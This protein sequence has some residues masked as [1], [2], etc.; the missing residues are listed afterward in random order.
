MTD[1]VN[2]YLQNVDGTKYRLTFDL[3]LLG[4]ELSDEF[5]YALFHQFL[6]GW[7]WL[8]DLV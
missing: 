4:V 5:L 2:E 6:A 8:K 1:L 7:A 3:T